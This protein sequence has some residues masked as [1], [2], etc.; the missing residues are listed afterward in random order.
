MAIEIEQVIDDIVSGR[1]GVE[2]ACQL[3]GEESQRDPARTR[4]WSQRVETALTRERI[5][6]PVA[7]QLFDALE[8]FRTDKT[9]WLDASAAVPRIGTARTAPA[10]PAKTRPRTAS[11]KLLEDVS[12]LRD[13]L[14]KTRPTK[15]TRD[16]WTPA[17]LDPEIEITTVPGIT[18]EDK[19]PPAMEQ[20]PIGT[21]I[22]DRY[23]LVNYMGLGGVGQVFGALDLSRTDRETHVTIKVIAV[24]LKHQPDAYAALEAAVRRSQRLIHPNVVS[25]YD[26]DRYNDQMF[27]VMEPL[28]G[29]WLSAL[30]REV[31]GKG[32]P[33]EKA[34]PIIEGIANGLAYAHKQ[35]IVHS[36]LSPHAVFLAEDGTPKIMGFGLIHAVPSSNESMDMLDTLTLRAYTEAYTAD[37]W[38]HQGIPAAAD[39]LYPLGVIAYEMLAGVHPFQRLSLS[40]ARQRQLKFNAIPGLSR[41]ARKLIGRCLSFERQVRPRDAAGF[42]KRMRP[43]WFQRM[44][45][46]QA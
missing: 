39:D 34:W 41:H 3:V 17:P 26:L 11:P 22:N 5:S 42:V 4:F 7:R 29:R 37:A 10:S 33:Y 2:A 27:L 12:Q 19:P 15:S 20:I 14:F 18:E 28:R 1:L 35:G 38:S 23:R 6:R 36:D 30:V 16:W 31:R 21:V 13:A 9:V 40:V 32:L 24:N 8:N 45:A 43:N 44:L 46:S 25:I